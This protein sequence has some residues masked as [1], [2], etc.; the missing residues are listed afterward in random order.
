MQSTVL[1][2]KRRKPHYSISMHPTLKLLLCADGYSVAV[3]K[4]M[5]NITFVDTIVFGLV[6]IV[7]RISKVVKESGLQ[8]TLF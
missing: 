6:E 5:E 4:L 7:Q 1:P 8:V 3:L 2:P